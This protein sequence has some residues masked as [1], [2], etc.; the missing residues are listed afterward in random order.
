MRREDQDVAALAQEELD[1]VDRHAAPIGVEAAG[2]RRMRASHAS[3]YHA[4]DAGAQAIGTDHKRRARFDRLARRI[5]C[6]HADDAVAVADDLAHQRRF[7]YLGAGRARRIDQQLVEHGAAR[8][9]HHRRAVDRFRP[10]AQGDRPGMH[11][12]RL[13]HWAAGFRKRIEKTPARQRRRGAR[14]QEVREIVSLGKR[15]RSS[16][17]TRRPRR[18]RACPATRRRT[19]HRR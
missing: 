19:A 18:A 9:V 12:D 15:A 7:P 16:T 6:P 17:S 4:G 3:P 2:Q 11:G 5:D 8:A 10:S 14:P 1:A 13:D